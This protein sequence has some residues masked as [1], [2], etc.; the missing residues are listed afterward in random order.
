MEE[1]SQIEDAAEWNEAEHY[2]DDDTEELE[3]EEDADE[4]PINY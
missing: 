3:A 1:S 4:G 2:P